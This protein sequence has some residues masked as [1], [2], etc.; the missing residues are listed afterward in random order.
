MNPNYNKDPNTFEYI[1]YN[2][3]MSEHACFV[4]ENFVMKS[5]F[6]KLFVIAHSAGG[7]CVM[8]IQEKFR[9]SFFTQVHKIAFTDSWVTKS[10]YLSSNE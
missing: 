1:P 7:A 10:E 4:W 8:S 5:G 3:S 6:D 9:K 2:S